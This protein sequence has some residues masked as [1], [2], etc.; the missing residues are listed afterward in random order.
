M[1]DA[2]ITKVKTTGGIFINIPYLEKSPNRFYQTKGVFPILSNA[3][4]YEGVIRT[5]GGG[6]KCWSQKSA[7]RLSTVQRHFIVESNA[8]PSLLQTTHQN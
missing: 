1:N 2:T 7:D 5:L 6:V 4:T 8:E 3:D